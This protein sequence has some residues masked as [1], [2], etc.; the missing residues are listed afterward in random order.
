MQAMGLATFPLAYLLF[1][2][3]NDRGYSVSKPLGILLVGYVSWILSV[4]HIAP[5]IRLTLALLLLALGAVSAA[6]AWRRRNELK[7]FISRE[8][9]TIV[10][11]EVVFLAIFVGWAVFRAY[12]PAIDHTE[13]PMDFAFLNASIESRIG[14]PEDP[15]MRG[16][17]ISY[18]YFGYWMMGG[19][20][21]LSGVASNVSY[22]LSLALI[23]AMAAMAAFGLVYNIARAQTASWRRAVGGGLAAVLLLGV[24]ANLEGMLEIMHANGIGPDRFWSWIRID[25]LDPPA[26]ESSTGWAPQGFWWWFHA[27]RVINTFDGTLGIDYT[28]HEFPFFSF[29]LGDLHPHVMSIPFT[30][31]FAAFCWNFLQTPARGFHWRR[32]GTYAGVAAMGL[33]LGGLAFTNLWD[34]PTFSALFLGVAV[35]RVYRARRTD[36]WE[37]LRETLPF[38][39]AVVGLAILPFLPYYLNLGGSFTGIHAVTMATTRPIHAFIVWGPY[40]AAVVPFI[41]FALWRTRLSR[42]WPGRVAFALVVVTVPYLTWAYLHL[43]TGG[44][45][46]DLFG[47]SIRVLPLA[48]LVGAAVYSSLCL[49]RQE[50]SA[51]ASFTMLLSALGLFMIMGPEL[52]FVGDSFGIRMNTVFKLYYQAWVLLAVVSGLAILNWGSLRTGATGWM[53]SLNTLWAVAFVI[54]LV[55]SLY[56]APAAASS[57]VGNFGDGPSI[58]GLDFVGRRSQ[59]ERDAIQYVRENVDHGSAVLEAVGEWF[60]AGLISRS[61]GVPTVINWPGHQMQWR[62]SRVALETDGQDPVGVCDSLEG[63]EATRYLVCREADVTRIYQ[64]QDTEEAKNLLARYDVEYVYVGPRERQK[65]GT[66]GLAKFPALA[67]TVFSKGDVAIYRVRR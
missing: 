37:T 47:R 2:R 45:T 42:D 16:E 23:P 55:P 57:K 14:P 6:Y 18:Y 13:Q 63:Q 20:S 54:V 10:A 48:F 60:D 7:D 53:R 1:S 27:T 64:T 15:W 58:D 19:V 51:A 67:E 41:I 39:F 36:V 62:G 17:S 46:T 61:T 21:E 34:L 4:L 26:S 32:A 31:L 49:A 56:Y 66:D 11:A 8:W 5:S 9:R 12:D 43:Q 30:L 59:A 44:E 40:L 22:N 33:A 29:M 52:L 28:I 35:L 50:R 65:Y 25:G 38:A 3:L 24:A